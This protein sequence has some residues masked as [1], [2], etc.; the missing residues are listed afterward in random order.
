MKMHVAVLSGAVLLLG[1][2]SPALAQNCSP[3]DGDNWPDCIWATN[4]GQ[5]Y[6]AF[7]RELDSVSTWGGGFVTPLRDRSP[8]LLASK[9]MKLLLV[10][11]A[12]V[13]IT[14]AYLTGRVDGDPYVIA[15]V[16]S[17]LIAGLVGWCGLAIRR[18]SQEHASLP[19]DELKRINLPEYALKK[20][21][22]PAWFTIVFC[23]VFLP[24]L[25]ITEGLKDSEKQRDYKTALMLEPKRF[26]EH[27]LACSLLE[28]SINKWRKDELKLDPL[29][30]DIICGRNLEGGIVAQQL[31]RA[32]RPAINTA[33]EWA[34]NMPIE[35]LTPKGLRDKGR[36]VE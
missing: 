14:T 11:A 5:P 30:N 2:F 15:A 36:H 34:V 27:L 22:V 25:L 23:V 16:I 28:M 3:S 6:E 31:R 13:G 29:P 26:A 20:A 24:S 32:L 8:R 4:G 19:E 7:G 35:V 9:P 18:G 12:S 1:V 10:A 17:A 21:S 33:R